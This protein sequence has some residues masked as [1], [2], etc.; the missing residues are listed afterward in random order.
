M[1]K[2]STGKAVLST[3][4]EKRPK[5]HFPVCLCKDLT[6]GPRISGSL[7]QGKDKQG[8]ICLRSAIALVG[9][10]RSFAMLIRACRIERGA[11]PSKLPDG[12]SRSLPSAMASIAEMLWVRTCHSFL[13]S[14][15]N[16]LI[17]WC[18]LI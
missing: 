9:Q 16:Y 18:T 11:P 7:P 14:L 8:G 2:R 6:R 12:F 15:N 4:R 17:Q 10:R 3:S 13:H 1:I 5:G